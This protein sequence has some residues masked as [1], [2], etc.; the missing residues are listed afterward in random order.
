MSESKSSSSS[1]MSS[2]G[3]LI[4]LIFICWLMQIAGCEDCKGTSSGT[5]CA[6]KAIGEVYKEMKVGFD[7]GNK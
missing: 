5:E 2:V 4:L 1:G 7:K 6:G 3:Y